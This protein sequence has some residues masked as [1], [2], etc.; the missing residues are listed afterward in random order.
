MVGPFWIFQSQ[1][2][3]PQYL[4]LYL[5]TISHLLEWKNHWLLQRVAVWLLRAIRHFTLWMVLAYDI[6]VNKTIGFHCP[7][8]CDTDVVVLHHNRPS[9]N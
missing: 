2:N 8:N 5:T 1:T 6:H 4:E 3:A 7:E 9:W